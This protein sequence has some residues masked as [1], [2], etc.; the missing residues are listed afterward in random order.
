MFVGYWCYRRLTGYFS[1]G[2]LGNGRAPEKYLL[3]QGTVFGHVLVQCT[4]IWSVS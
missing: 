3:I 2:N 1:I 4:S